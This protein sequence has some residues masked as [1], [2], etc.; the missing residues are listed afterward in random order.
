MARPIEDLSAREL[1]ELAKKKL[2]LEQEETKR[3]EL[4]S[5]AMEFKKRHEQLLA[6]HEQQLASIEREFAALTQRRAQ[7][8]GS[9]QSKLSDI[10][11]EMASVKSSVVMVE[12][13][14]TIHILPVLPAETPLAK[15][16]RG[17]ADD[18]LAET[19]L[20]IMKGRMDISDSLLRE[21]LRASGHGL[22]NLNKILE[23]L[24]R[25]GKITAHGLGNYGLK[26]RI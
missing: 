20:E 25:E 6:R 9:F 12:T 21:K 24:V 2:H 7:V 5:R 10:E 18:T 1:F 16:T 4:A 15:E 19:I 14:G 23:R 22:T 3:A 17:S 8:I 13:E 26:R 11:R